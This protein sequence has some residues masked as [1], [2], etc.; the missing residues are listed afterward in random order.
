M[1]FP[2]QLEKHV[3]NRIHLVQLKSQPPPIMEHK[4]ARSMYHF[5]IGLPTGKTNHPLIGL[6]FG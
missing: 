1:K 2:S 5:N 3:R 6:P 4:T